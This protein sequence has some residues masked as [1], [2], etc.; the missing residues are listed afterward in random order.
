MLFDDHDD[1]LIEDDGGVFSASPA[2]EELPLPR[3]AI[4]SVGHSTIENQLLTLA[5]SGKMPHAMIFSGP[6]GIGKS[7]MAFRFAKFLLSQKPQENLGPSLFGDPEPPTTPT[8]LSVDPEIQAARLVTSSGHPDL[9]TLARK[10]DEKTG[11]TKESLDVE[12]IRSVGP[13]LNLTPFMGGWRIVIV[14]DADT[15]TRSSQNAL[16][17][18]LEEP[19][20]N[21]VL[22][23]IAHRP[24]QLIP[25]IR[26]RSRMIE[27][28]TLEQ[29]DFET[30]LKKGAAQT[31]G[32][33]ALY[34]I[35]GGSI[36]TALRLTQSGALKALDQLTKLLDPWPNLN[37]TD[38]HLMGE[39]L[40]AKGQD[41]GLQGFQE[42]LLWSVETITK[43]KARGIGTL[44]SPLNAGPFPALMNHYT[45][46]HWSK[47][48]DNLNAHFA[49][50][51]YGSLDRRQAVFGAFSILKETAS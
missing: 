34:N 48:C 42:V 3:A 40:N 13:F 51:K 43:C 44:P 15:M 29:N 1:D 22:I 50:V 35:S 31:T 32:L 45:L 21:S 46:E 37:W 4:H 27:F 16:L 12:Q 36:G 17:K 30:L 41:D 14:D 25:T 19:P 18:V 28:S 20:G 24:G 11:A 38:I 8:T 26:S 10:A 2:P 7:T 5:A 47:I 39:V 49:T 9:L 33:E 6:A 23:L